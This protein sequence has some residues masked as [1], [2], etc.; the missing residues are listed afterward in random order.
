MICSFLTYWAGLLKE[1]LRQQVNRGAEA[2]KT[3]ALLFH[4][5]EMRSQAQD[6]MQLIPFVG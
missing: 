3:A 1:D 6:E 5:Q 2:V 4:G